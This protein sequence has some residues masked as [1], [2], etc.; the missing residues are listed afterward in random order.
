MDVCFRVHKSAF[1]CYSIRNISTVHIVI[2][3]MDE[4]FTDVRKMPMAGLDPATSAS[5]IAV[6]KHGN[7][8][9]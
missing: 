3:E 6:Y 5:L 2:K 8:T 4:R 7:L 9:N 1:I